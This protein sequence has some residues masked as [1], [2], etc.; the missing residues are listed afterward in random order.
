MSA[1]TVEPKAK[2]QE[3]P[4][5]EM[6]KPL[7]RFV[8]WYTADDTKREKPTPAI[9]TKVGF[10]AVSLTLIIED[11]GFRTISGV[12]HISDPDAKLERFSQF[13]VWD[14]TFETKLL[15]K[16]AAELGAEG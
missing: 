15:K 11:R 7:S 13:G 5:Y 6:P 9:M 8:Y 3:P 12:R 2:T 16:L 4:E 1:A 10:R 14:D